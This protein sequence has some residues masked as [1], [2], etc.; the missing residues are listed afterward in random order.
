MIRA[1]S[2]DELYPR[3]LTARE[4]GRTLHLI[5]VRTPEEY[6]Q[7]RIPGARLL[8]LAGL[9]ARAGEIPRDGEVFVVCHSGVR[10]AQAVM[11]LSRQFGHDNLINVEGGIVAWAQ[12]GYPLETE[13]T[14]VTT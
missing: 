8:P 13:R 14:E 7:A 5:D 9:M 12:A 4:N 2:V 10:S 11:Y 1:A 6:R 3:W